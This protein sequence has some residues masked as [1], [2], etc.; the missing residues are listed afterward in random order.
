M[1]REQLAPRVR[2]QLDS[3]AF[4]AHAKGE[5]ISLLEYIAYVHKHKPLLDS[6][7]N[8]DIIPGKRKERRTPQLI[9]FAAK[10][11]RENF[12]AMRRAGLNPLPVFHQEESYHWLDRMIEDLQDDK[13]PYIALSTFK[14]LSIEQNR[15]WLDHCFTRLTDSQGKPLMRVHGL[16]IGHF[17]L[18]RRYPWF[19]CDATTWAL[20]AAFGRVPV[21]VYRSGKP[22]YS[23]DPLHITVSMQGKNDGSQA[24]QHYGFMGPLAQRY[25]NDFFKEVGI[26]MKEATDPKGYEA[27]ARAAA[28]FFMRFR[29]TLTPQPFRFRRRDF[30][31]N[32]SAP[33]N[34]HLKGFDLPHVRL[35][36]ATWALAE[37][38]GRIL[39][40]EG[41][42]DRLVSYWEIKDRDAWVLPEYVALGKIDKPNRTKQ[43]N[44]A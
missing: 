1:K 27:R 25:V 42:K 5:S 17:G 37:Y 2:L 11:S 28:F 32:Q 10:A 8:L 18:L 6:Y 35:I 29:E 4:S 30:L 19:S 21:P 31:G 43:R 44:Q 23:Q 34:K 41:I 15:A 20:G 33:A 7:F 24:M 16:G 39:T 9:E 38:Q 26:T 40:E 22:D 36:F 12:L 13:D 14:T 3:G